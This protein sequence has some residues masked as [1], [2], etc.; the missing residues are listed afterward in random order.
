MKTRIVTKSQLLLIG[1]LVAAIVT[2]MAVFYQPSSQKKSKSSLSEFPK[3]GIN[4]PIKALA[5]AP[6]AG[7][8][9]R[10]LTD[11]RSN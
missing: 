1:I 2:L 9:V 4:I 5:I 6:I 11:R 3:F 7:W 10:Q 8:L